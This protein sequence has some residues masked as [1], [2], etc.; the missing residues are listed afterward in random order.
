MKGFGETGR[1]RERRSKIIAPQ[2]DSNGLGGNRFLHRT[3]YFVQL[4]SHAMCKQPL[5]ISRCSWPLLKGDSTF[6]HDTAGGN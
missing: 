1:E 6:R 3:L 5:C 4:F 2:T